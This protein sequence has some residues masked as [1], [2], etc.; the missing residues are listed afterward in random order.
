MLAELGHSQPDATLSQTPA[1]G[2]PPKLPHGTL[3]DYQILR[4]IGRGGMGVV[5]EAEQVSLGRKVAR[6]TDAVRPPPTPGSCDWQ[7]NANVLTRCGRPYPA[8]H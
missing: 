5:Y 1:T 7:S 8:L 6:V 3:G 2:K 4:E